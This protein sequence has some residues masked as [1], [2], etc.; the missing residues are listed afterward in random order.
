MCEAVK[1]AKAGR[2]NGRETNVKRNSGAKSPETEQSKGAKQF[3]DQFARWVWPEIARI[4]EATR[5]ETVS[6]KVR[7]LCVKQIQF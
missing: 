6:T 4:E 1:Q 2:Q 5:G 3:V 7:H